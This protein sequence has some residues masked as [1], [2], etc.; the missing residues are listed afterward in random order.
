MSADEIHARIVRY[1]ENRDE[2]PRL[3]VE[4]HERFGWSWSRI[5]DLVGVHV[6]TLYRWARRPE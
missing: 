6:S 5:A 1:R 2:L 4:L 3:C